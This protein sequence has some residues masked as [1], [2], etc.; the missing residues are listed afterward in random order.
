MLS[1]ARSRF[2]IPSQFLFLALQ[3]VTL[4]TAVVYDAKTPDLYENNAHYKLRWPLFFISAVWLFLGL[5]NF[6]ADRTKATGEASQP[7][8]AA[9]MARYQR[10][11]QPSEP[12]RLSHD[13]GQGTERNSSSLYGHSRS[14]SAESDPLAS[15]YH[16][17]DLGHVDDID[18]EKPNFLQSSRVDRL[19]SR[20]VPRVA[21]GRSLKAVRFFYVLIERTIL[22]LGFV[23]VLMG[24]ATIGGIAVSLYIH[25]SPRNT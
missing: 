23:L 20:F 2:T 14:S 9:V 12:P 4:L 15:P 24:T 8:S 17:E 19:M 25:D 3:A 22:L 6:Y 13:S 10:L 21:A 1:V 16:D 11:Q 18:D 7:L 5:V